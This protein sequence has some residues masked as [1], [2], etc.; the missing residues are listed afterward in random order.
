MLMHRDRFPAGTH[1]VECIYLFRLGIIWDFD[2]LAWIMKKET[3][4][5]TASV[6]ETIYRAVCA[7]SVC[8]FYFALDQTKKAATNL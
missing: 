2:L 4:S 3:Y 8:N 6:A 1:E 7:S 5:D